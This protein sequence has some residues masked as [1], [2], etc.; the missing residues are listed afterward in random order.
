MT[1]KIPSKIIISPFVHELVKRIHDLYPWTEWSGIARLEKKDWHYLMSDIEFWEQV[2]S[3]ALTTISEDGIAE[4]MWRI[5]DTKPELLW[6]YNCRIHSHHSMERFWSGTD[7][8]QKN[9]FDN[10]YTSHFFHV[11]TNYTTV[12]KEKLPWYTWALTFYKPKKIEFVV[13]CE[14]G[15]D[16]DDCI[17]LC[18]CDW[19][20]DSIDSIKESWTKEIEAMQPS[21]DAINKQREDEKSRAWDEATRLATEKAQI[22][23]WIKSQS[24]DDIVTPDMIDII[25]PSSDDRTIIEELLS[26]EIDVR[27]KELTDFTIKSYDSKIANLLIDVDNKYDTEINTLIDDIWDR[28]STEISQLIEA[29]LPFDS[30]IE[31]LKS[32]IKRWKKPVANWFYKRDKRDDVWDY[33]KQKNNKVPNALNFDTYDIRDTIAEIVSDN[34]LHY[35][36]DEFF[37]RKPWYL[38]KPIWFEAYSKQDNYLI[39]HWSYIPLLEIYNYIMQ[40]KWKRSI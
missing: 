5:A 32:A 15:G 26:D 36:Y 21:I 30:K 22:I 10:W 1:K 19:V 14:I 31:E 4:I 37:Y 17:Q 25:N 34:L 20:R 16:Y 29:C 28:Y 38:F 7:N 6:E 9:S 3:T 2:N 39:I 11:V 13:D 33:W 12:N 24:F 23:E 8:A 27:K 18:E 40:T 35:D